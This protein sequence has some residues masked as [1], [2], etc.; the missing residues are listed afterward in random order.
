[1]DLENTTDEELEKI[2]RKAENQHVGGSQFNRAQLELEIRRKRRLFEQQEKIL[3]TLQSR[4]DKIIHILSYINKQ[5][6][7]SALI[8]GLGA[9][10]IGVLI[11]IIST[12][13][14]VKLGLVG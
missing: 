3:A 7:I 10:I 12:Y 2:I 13:L 4:L 14:Q 6:L 9:I 8:A 5:P 11:N 1:M